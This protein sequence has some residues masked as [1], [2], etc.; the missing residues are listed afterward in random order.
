MLT[1]AQTKNNSILE[2]GGRALSFM[3]GAFGFEQDN[4]LQRVI[5]N[6]RQMNQ[7]KGANAKNND[8]LREIEE[9]SGEN[10]IEES[11]EKDLSKSN[12]SKSLN[13]SLRGDK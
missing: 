12:D 13:I 2:N 6:P 8:I 3:D 4:N 11:A 10:L 9:F 7:H 1:K 5:S